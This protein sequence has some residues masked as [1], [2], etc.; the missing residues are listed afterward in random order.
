[1]APDL[2]TSRSMKFPDG[3]EMMPAPHHTWIYLSVTPEGL[4]WPSRE[5]CANSLNFARIPGRWL[6]DTE[7]ETTEG[8]VM[9]VP[10]T[11]PDGWR[12]GAIDWR[13]TTAVRVVPR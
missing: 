6:N 9:V 1:M 12:Y 3:A 10:P 4:N 5:D 13:E 8:N 7:F 11:S 2:T